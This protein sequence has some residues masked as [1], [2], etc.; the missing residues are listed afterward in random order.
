[1]CNREILTNFQTPI[2]YSGPDGNY[3]IYS[4]P[5]P[6]K[7][8][9]KCPASQNDLKE[10]KTEIKLLNGTGILYHTKNCHVYSNYFTLL[11]F[12]N[13]QT[14]SEIQGNH[15]IVPPIESILTPSERSL[16]QKHVT[17]TA[18]KQLNQLASIQE[19]INNHTEKVN[20]ITIETLERKLEL[21]RSSQKPHTPTN[22]SFSFIL[23]IALITTIIV[24]IITISLL[25]Y[26][27]VRNCLVPTRV[28]QHAMF[29]P[30]APPTR[31]QTA[32]IYEEIQPETPGRLRFV[33][34]S[35]VTSL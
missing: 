29:T 8:I 10:M 25:Q 31:T 17:S 9:Q 11:P 7:A 23:C 34:E 15:I 16:F 35:T 6:I 33:E 32:V 3:W 13:R 12:T 21:I 28:T 20:S 5:I 4:T 14:Y 19:I 18:D 27:C 24:V 1:M 26:P 2:L 22:T 30:T